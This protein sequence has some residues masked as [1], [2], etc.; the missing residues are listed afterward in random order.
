MARKKLDSKLQNNLKVKICACL[1]S[2]DGFRQLLKDGNICLYYTF[3]F[4]FCR[5]KDEVQHTCKNGKWY[6]GTDTT[7]PLEDAEWKDPFCKYCETSLEIVPEPG[8]TLICSNIAEPG[9]VNAAGKFEVRL[10]SIVWLFLIK[11]IQNFR[12]DNSYSNFNATFI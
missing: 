11:S 3:F 2:P 6:R 5:C 9:S 1:S 10:K 7:T 4:S 12:K 8:L